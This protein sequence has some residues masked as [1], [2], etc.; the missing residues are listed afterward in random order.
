MKDHR[1]S[2]AELQ[3]LWN[4]R[5]E[6]AEEH[7]ARARSDVTKLKGEIQSRDSRTADIHYAYQQALRAENFALANYA[8]ILTIVA[9][10]T[11]G[12]TVPDDEEP[13]SKC[14]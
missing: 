11:L 10:L 9:D 7:L 8:K 14:G 12:R 3:V 6:E 1:K 2:L 4:T 5:L 13:E